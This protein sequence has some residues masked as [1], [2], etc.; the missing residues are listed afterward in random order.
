MK[1][2]SPLRKWL[3]VSIGT[4]VCGV[5]LAAGAAG[6]ARE[7]FV[8]GPAATQIFI[9]PGGTTEFDSDIA[10]LN[11]RTGEVH[12]FRGDVNVASV[13]NTWELRVAAVKEANSGI[14]EIQK[15]PN[16]HD[17]APGHEATF[18]VDV[19]TGKTWILRHRASTN[20]SWNL[21]ADWN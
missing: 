7:Y 18:L 19:V 2:T 13:Q 5:G 15:V 16:F 10:K 20:A 12:R 8:E 4:A 11:T 1:L 17:P 6:V 9:L 3:V 21:V 14:L